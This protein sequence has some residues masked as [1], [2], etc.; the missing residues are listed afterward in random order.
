[1]VQEEATEAIEKLS[2]RLR[3]ERDYNKFGLEMEKI[4]YE[5]TNVQN[6][7]QQVYDE[8]SRSNAYSKFMRTLD[9]TQS[10]YQQLLYLK[11][12]QI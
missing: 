1:M 7:A 6:W 3:A 10:S 2:D 8:I 11:T 4:E 5:Y 12:Q 9:E